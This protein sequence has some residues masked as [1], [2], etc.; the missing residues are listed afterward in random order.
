ME[1]PFRIL[2]LNGGGVR[3]IFQAVFLQ[4]LSEK[5]P[6]PF[7]SNFD[8][9]C[10]TSTGSIVGMAVAF[11]IS[12]D[13][14]V[15]LYKEK[16]KS[17]FEK[18]SI[19][20]FR[21]GPLYDQEILRNE[22]TKVFGNKQL[23]QAKTKILITSA[24]I[25]DYKHKVFSNFHSFVGDESLSA[26]DVILSSSAAPTYFMPVKPVTQE[27]HYVDGGL[28]A[29]SPSSLSILFANK[30]LK[31]PITEINLLSVG[32]GDFPKGTTIEHFKKMRRFSLSAIETIFEL[33]FS[34]QASFADN[35]AKEILG[36]DRYLRVSTNLDSP[37]SLDDVES[38]VSK[39]PSHAEN[40]IDQYLQE[41]IVLL[42][43]DGI[44]SDV[45][46][47]L[48]RED[49]ISDDLVKETGLS[50]FFPTRK[51]YDIRGDNSSIHSYVDTAKD[52]L[53]MVSI[54][55]IKGINFDDL[56]LILERKLEDKNS[57]F[58][59]TISLINPDKSCL[60]EALCPVFEK[61]KEDLERDIR[62]GVKRLT[63]F[64]NKLS[65]YA[66]DK[67]HL[68]VHNAIPFGSAII[69]DNDKPYGKIQ[70]ETKVYKVP[71][72][73][74]FA[75]EVVPY[76]HDGFYFTLVEG[77]KNLLKDGNKIF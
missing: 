48:K 14:I 58:N 57:N 63:E 13:L 38:A 65:S 15:S 3:G 60:L 71:M 76:K 8:L 68:Y 50:A 56:R 46:N 40:A 67:L 16:G 33:M 55:L 2:S 70:I 42:K 21:R 31:I 64:R 39:L 22:L 23:G 19:N 36:K 12:L 44:K 75:F 77:Y 27:S 43:H 41:T 66:K 28:W 72:G 17:I 20:G 10:G 25:A 74:S 54:S 52:N 32:T 59:V 34:S 49:L 51:H 35:Y 1:K 47:H 18:K 4:K 26:V 30:Y 29:N 73:K 7:Y 45:I 5:L 69:I 6:K 61:D 62:D 9:I 53:I 24:S 37:I 11:D